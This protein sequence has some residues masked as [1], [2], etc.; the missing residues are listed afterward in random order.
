M[1]KYSYLN[2]HVFIFIL[3]MFKMNQP[4]LHTA[5]L[6]E[7]THFIIA[8]YFRITLESLK[9][10]S[11]IK[12]RNRTTATFMSLQKKKTKKQIITRLKGRGARTRGPPLS[13][14][15]NRIKIYHYRR[16][17]CEEIKLKPTKVKT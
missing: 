7:K 6:H 3:I 12:V 2:N 15:S 4:F 10:Q 9:S 17:L 1:Y 13:V 11:R 14:K 8:N 16:R 5:K